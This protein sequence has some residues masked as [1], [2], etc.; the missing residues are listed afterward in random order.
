MLVELVQ[1]EISQVVVRDLLGK[2][3]IDGGQDFVGYCHRRPLVP[4]P[5]LETVELVPQVGALGLGCRVGGF[6]QCRLQIDI[7][8]GDAAALALAGRFVVP[9]HT[10]AQE[11]SCETLSNTLMSTPSSAIITAARV[12]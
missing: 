6:Y 7:A 12:Q 10:P 1:V 5:S 11:A 2:H 4:A 3:V 9:G 8:F